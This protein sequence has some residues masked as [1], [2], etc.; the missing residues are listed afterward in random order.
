MPN[1]NMVCAARRREKKMRELSTIGKYV[2][3]TW[4][5]YG[6]LAQHP[7]AIFSIYM[8]KI[9]RHTLSLRLSLSRAR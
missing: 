6:K 5:N 4:L 9:H 3:P 2:E 1:A 7:K 8:C